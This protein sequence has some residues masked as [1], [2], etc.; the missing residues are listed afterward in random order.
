MICGRRFHTDRST[1]LEQSTLSDLIAMDHTYLTRMRLRQEILD[2][3]RDVTVR[4]NEIA[5]PAVFEFYRW[6]FGVYLPRRFPTVYRLVNHPAGGSLQALYNQASDVFIPTAPPSDPLAALRTLGIQIDTDFILL[7][8]TS[9]DAEGAAIYHLHAFVN[10]CPSGFNL[11]EKLGLPL[12][13]VH[14]GVPGYQARLARSMDKTFARLERGKLIRRSNWTI[15]TN[16]RLLNLGGTH[17][18]G[19]TEGEEAQ[20][21]V[22]VEQAKVKIEECRL[23]SER[24]TLFRLPESGAIVFSFKT[25]LY[26]LE[27][28]KRRGHAAALAEAIEG[29]GRGNVPEF[30]YY[31]RKVIWG[32]KVLEY[33]RT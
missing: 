26:T 8:P 14:G 21:Q 18:Y 10:P 17:L 22:E 4:C 16:D 13:G 7:L 27:E 31:K 24:Q 12:S 32:P 33:L 25:Y 2:Q 1:A 6:M 15:T 30:E 19:D 11:S 5:Q 28:V 3:N 9:R 23:R 29:L 20:R